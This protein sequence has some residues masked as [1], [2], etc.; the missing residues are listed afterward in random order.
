MEDSALYH[1]VQTSQEGDLSRR[2]HQ[3]LEA[4]RAGLAEIQR[5]VD[6]I[7]TR[8]PGS[9]T[10]TSDVSAPHDSEVGEG[11]A[12]NNFSVAYLEGVEADNRL[13]RRICEEKV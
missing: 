1:L 11:D 4:T 6:E 13:L 12:E 7:Q 2:M 3:E 9:T 8:I 10:E 5:A